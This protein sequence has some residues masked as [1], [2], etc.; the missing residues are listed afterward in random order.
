MNEVVIEDTA[1]VAFLMLRGHKVMP[2]RKVED[3]NRIAF[4]VAGDIKLDMD[5]YNKNYEVG[6]QDYVKS[7]KMVRSMMFNAKSVSYSPRM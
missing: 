5:L 3:P 6:I 4:S 7:L 2:I 1:L